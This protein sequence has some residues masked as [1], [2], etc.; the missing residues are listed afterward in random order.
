[1]NVNQSSLA[2]VLYNTKCQA[3][4][5][6]NSNAKYLKTTQTAKCDQYNVGWVTFQPIEGDIFTHKLSSTLKILVFGFGFVFENKKQTDLIVMDFS[7]AFDTVLHQRLLRKLSHCGI[8]GNIHSWLNKFLTTRK[9]CVVVG[10]ENLLTL[11]GCTVWSSARNGCW[12]AFVSYL[13]K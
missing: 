6:L 7:K 13:F 10:G 5:G 8:V 4:L 12:T 1:M 11:G 2:T 9:Q 3:L